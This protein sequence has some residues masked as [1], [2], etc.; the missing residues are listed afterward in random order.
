MKEVTSRISKLLSSL[1]LIILVLS[2]IVGV[3]VGIEGDSFGILV[4][5]IT[6]GV[7]TWILL[8]TFSEIIRLLVI[9]ANN[10]NLSS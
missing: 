5:Y 3:F 2:I 1:A 8:K 7:I 9:I 4:A 10:T 6:S